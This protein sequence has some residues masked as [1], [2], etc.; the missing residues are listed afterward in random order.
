MSEGAAVVAWLRGPE[1]T[2]WSRRRA[3]AGAGEYRPALGEL[4]AT[5]WRAT[6]PL[7]AGSDPCG[8]G[9]QKIPLAAAGAREGVAL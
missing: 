4:P 8:P 2:E 9:T 1:G 6:G 7:D 3:L 5:C